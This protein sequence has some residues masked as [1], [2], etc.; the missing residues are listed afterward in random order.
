MAKPRPPCTPFAERRHVTCS[1][2]CCG[3][4][5]LLCIVAPCILHPRST[6]TAVCHSERPSWACVGRARQW[7][8][9]TACVHMGMGLGM[10]A[11]T[12]TGMGSVLQ[13]HVVPIAEHGWQPLLPGY[14]ERLLQQ[15]CTRVEPNGGSRG[16]PWR[17]GRGGPPMLRH[18]EK[19]MTAI[20]S[21]SDSNEA[22]VCTHTPCNIVSDSDS[23]VAASHVDAHQRHVTKT[24]RR[25][26]RRI[27]H[28]L[29]VRCC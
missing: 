2:A 15:P 11:F 5:V 17:A 10:A 9:T 6:S 28:M 13:R 19:R 23:R 24:R 16:L 26:G 7:T 27:A 20:P 22:V 8:A 21:F 25:H 18:V 3:C 29:S 4:T 14:E 1:T 12:T